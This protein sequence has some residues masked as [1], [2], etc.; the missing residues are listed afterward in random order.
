MLS[1]VLF[2]NDAVV[3]I[4]ARMISLFGPIDLE[5][6]LKGQETHKYFTKEYDLFYMNEVGFR[7]PWEMLSIM[8]CSVQRKLITFENLHCRKLIKWNSSSLKRPP[9]RIIC[10]F[11]TWGSLISL[12]IYSRSIQKDDQ[13]RRKL[14]HIR[15]FR[16]RTNNHSHTK[17]LKKYSL[18]IK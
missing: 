14:L 2:P 17:I 15:G 8:F 1:Q 10:R 13:L 12:Q 16:S 4:L 18:S 11:S 7:F 3:M 5:M 9:W 6:L